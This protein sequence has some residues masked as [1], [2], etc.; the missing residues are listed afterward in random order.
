MSFYLDPEGCRITYAEWLAMNVAGRADKGR[1]H[2]DLHDDPKRN[3]EE[4]SKVTEKI[5]EDGCYGYSCYYKDHPSISLN[6]LTYHSEGLRNYVHHLRSICCLVVRI[7]PPLDHDNPWL[8]RM[9]ELI[10]EIT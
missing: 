2:F 9:D 3:R 5:H 8:K 10:R 4:H 1:I 6:E 7:G